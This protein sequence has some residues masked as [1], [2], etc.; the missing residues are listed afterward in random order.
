M[1]FLWQFFLLLHRGLGS[2]CCVDFLVVL[3]RDDGVMMGAVRCVDCKAMQRDRRR[4][5]VCVGKKVGS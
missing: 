3:V 1:D 4:E 2:E 5:K